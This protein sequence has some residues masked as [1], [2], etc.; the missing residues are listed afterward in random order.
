MNHGRLEVVQVLQALQD[1]HA[2]VLDDLELGPPDLVQV[3]A[4]TERNTC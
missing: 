3:A 2:P 1:L 4:I